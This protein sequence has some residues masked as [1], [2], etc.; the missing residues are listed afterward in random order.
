ML[1]QIKRERD[2]AA[3][4]NDFIYHERVPTAKDLSQVPSDGG[5]GKIELKLPILGSEVKDI[6]TDLV[7]LGF[8]DAKN[9]ADGMRRSLVALEIQR[10][11][12]ATNELNA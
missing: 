12:E 5:I 10:L 9:Q 7:P 2:A 3:K 4:D 11:R 6:F 1:E 8:L